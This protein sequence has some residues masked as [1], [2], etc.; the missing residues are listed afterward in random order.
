[1]LQKDEKDPLSNTYSSI[2]LQII[3]CLTEE[4]KAEAFQAIAD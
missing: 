2:C 3:T 4:V 1:M